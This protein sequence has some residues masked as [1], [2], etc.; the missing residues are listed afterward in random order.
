[1]K[2]Q[3]FIC[4]CVLVL[5]CGF[6]APA[7]AQDGGARI[8]GFYAGTFGEGET[9]QAA[10][11]AVGYRFTPRFGFDFEA[12]AMPD[13]KI[14]DS[15]LSGNNDGGRVVAFF[16]NFVTEFPSPARWL[17]PY[18]QGGGGVANVRS[19]EF[20]FQDP[21]GRPIPVEP[22]GRRIG[23]SLFFPPD[24]RIEDVRVIRTGRGRSDTNLALTVGG[25]VD[26][27][28]W[29]GLAVGPNISFIKL[30]GNGGDLDL[31]R[32]GVRAAYRF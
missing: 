6:A 12:F 25:G 3:A 4:L 20:E 21:D 22:R 8:S 27:T 15:D 31:T 18:V 9:N 10:G 17:T 30:Y 32:V 13:F 5:V 29:K 11:G 1:L 7:L 2:G 14:G 23:G 26:F 19:A 16:T 24:R 28:F